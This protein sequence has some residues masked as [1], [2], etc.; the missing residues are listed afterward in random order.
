MIIIMITILL[1]HSYVQNP[2]IGSEK[3]HTYHIES[4]NEYE[5]KKSHD[6]KKN[7]FNTKIIDNKNEDKYPHINNQRQLDVSNEVNNIFI[8]LFDEPF[9]PSEFS[10]IRYRS[11]EEVREKVK[12]V[13]EQLPQDG[14]M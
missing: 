7:N 12:T 8:R 10:D 9:T 6:I 2:I 13:F 11:S 1:F 5:S 3:K 4:N 14:F